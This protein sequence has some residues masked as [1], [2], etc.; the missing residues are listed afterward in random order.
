VLL[1]L[2]SMSFAALLVTLSAL[3]LH[4]GTSTIVGFLIDLQ[5][6]SLLAVPLMIFMSITPFFQ[7]FATIA[8]PIAAGVSSDSERD[9]L[10]NNYIQTTKYLVCI[11]YLAVISLFYI[12]ELIFGLWLLGPKTTLEDIRIINT[13]VTLLFAGY[14]LGLSSSIGRSIL[15]SVG[16]HWSS[17]FAELCTTLVGVLVGILLVYLTDLKVIGMALGIVLAMSA[18][19]L[20]IYPQLLSNYFGCSAYYIIFKT[21]V[22]PSLVCLPYIVMGLVIETFFIPIDNFSTSTVELLLIWLASVLLCVASIWLSIVSTE[23]RKI[24]FKLISKYV[25]G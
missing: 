10:F 6:V 5:S 18:K 21:T 19:G 9:K 3:L 24:V 11:S 14:T 2:L 7:T 17:S 25:Y 12:G 13:I 16:R 1:L 22:V 15:A 20:Y 23:H 4:Q 8:S